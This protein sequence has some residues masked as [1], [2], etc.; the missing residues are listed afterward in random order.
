MTVTE[1]GRGVCDRERA[2]SGVVDD[3]RDRAQ[4]FDLSGY[5][6]DQVSGENG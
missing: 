2:P 4:V 5:E 1:D 6:Q 3:G